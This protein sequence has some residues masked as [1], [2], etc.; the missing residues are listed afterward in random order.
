M[1]RRRAKAPVSR[2]EALDLTGFEPAWRAAI[3]ELLASRARLVTVAGECRPGPLQD[4]LLELV[5]RVEDGVVE[6]VDVARRAQTA[7]RAVST[8]E[9]DRVQ[10]ALKAARRRLAEAE[11]AGR[12]A[13]A[14]ATEV[15][16]LSD[17]HAALHQLANSADD[18]LERMR[19]LDLRL[20]AAV[21]RAVQAALLPDGTDVLASVGT[22]LGAVVDDLT[23]LRAGLD[24][25]RP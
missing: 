17:Q 12:D 1:F 6:A 24:A 18:A 7:T 4:R 9:L 25:V 13:T 11:A 22:E 20:D 19:L 16:L 3:D 8:M 10:D 2:V 15:A 5:S 21:A 23:A 14:A